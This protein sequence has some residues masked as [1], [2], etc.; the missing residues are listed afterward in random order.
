[1]PTYVV[2]AK[3][4]QQTFKSL[5]DAPAAVQ[6][7]KNLVQRLGGTI[8]GWYTLMGRFD[9]VCIL[10]APDDATVARI[11]LAVG[12]RYAIRTETMRAFDIDESL[13]LFA[14]KP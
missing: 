13:Q 7:A 3:W 5:K 8:K 12:E 11:V 1:M 10:E 2:L 4:T 14:G 6:E 9:E